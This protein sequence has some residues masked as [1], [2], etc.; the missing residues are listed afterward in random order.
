MDHLPSKYK[1]LSSNPQ[2]CQKKEKKNGKLN[3]YFTSVS[4]LAKLRSIFECYKNKKLNVFLFGWGK[5]RK[6]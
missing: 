3:D 6:V 1:A 5:N 2:Y 4:Y